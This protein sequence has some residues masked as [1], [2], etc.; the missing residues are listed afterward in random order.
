MKYPHKKTKVTGILVSL[1]SLRTSKSTGCGEFSDLVPLAEWCRDTGQQIIQLLPVQDT[2]TQSSPYSALSAFALH[3]IYIR[4]SETEEYRNAPA[5]ISRRIDSRLK[6]IKERY[7]GAVRFDYNGLLKEKMSLL[8]ELYG[9]TDAASVRSKDLTAFVRSHRWVR[10]YAVYRVLKERSDGAPWMNW[11]EHR[12]VDSDR[13]EALY[14]SRS[15]SNDIDFYVWLQMTAEEQFSTAGAA[16][17]KLGIAL[18]GDIPILMNEDSVD[19]WAERD[20]FTTASRAGA[21]PDM[22][23][24]LGQ[25]WDFP[26]YN[27]EALERRDYDW[28]KLRLKEASRFYHAYRIDHVL[29]FFRIWTIPERNF[30]G[31]PGYFWP[32]AGFTRDELHALG[33]D[34]GR[35]KWLREPHV[36]GSWLR[37]LLGERWHETAGNLFSRIGDED[38]Y[39]FSDAVMGETDITGSNLP[40]VAIGTVLQWY[41]DRALLELP[42]G[43]FTQSWTFRECSRYQALYDHERNVF[44]ALV[45]RAGEKSEE[46]WEKH[47]TKLLTFMKESTDMLTCAEDLGVIPPSVPRTLADMGI[48]GLRIPRWAREWGAPGE[49][50]ISLEDYPEM[51]VT[52]P[53]VHDT[54]TLREWWTREKGKELL[55]ELLYPGEVCPESYDAHTAERVV[56]GFSRTQSMILVF[57]I[58]D[59][60]ALSNAYRLPNEEDERIN[61]PGTYNDFNWTYRIP[62]PLETLISDEKIAET[63]RQI[64]RSRAK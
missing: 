19:V 21:P 8:R 49:P 38:L 31:I 61:I 54:S 10:S 63:I 30:S 2:G 22:F 50:L 11:S 51:T 62:I 46:L 60:L 40:D 64:I 9:V 53:S 23:S 12:D 18:K 36:Q 24:D 1:S 17:S 55:W 34:D 47:G 33:F 52:A 29:G 3:P 26:V 59:L 48:L 6:E 7:D 44:E 56:S 15:L 28:W 37:G 27:W 16:V 35:I 42:N 5:E 32:Q 43:M 39:L 45:H 13:I 57:Q 25:N 20:I 58:Q 14:K 4:V 41:R